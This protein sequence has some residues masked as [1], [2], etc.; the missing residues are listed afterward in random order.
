MSFMIF[1]ANVSRR[2][3]SER[4]VLISSGVGVVEN[5]LLELHRIKMVDSS[6]FFISC[7]RDAN[8]FSVKKASCVHEIK[9]WSP[10]VFDMNSCFISCC[11]YCCVV[12]LGLLVVV[13][14]S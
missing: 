10:L 4:L 14:Q 7:S 5:I 13:I 6:S 1:K 11:H 12:P 9:P 3:T 2:C 8:V